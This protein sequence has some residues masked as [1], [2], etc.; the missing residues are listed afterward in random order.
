MGTLLFLFFSFAGVQCV[1]LGFEASTSDP[2]APPTPEVLLYIA[3]VFGASLA[4]NVWIFYRVSGG[5]FNPAVTLGIMLL[6]GMPITKGVILIISQ[7]V[8]GIAAAGLVAAI[9]PGGVMFATTLSGGIS[10]TQGL[11]FEAF[12]TFELTFTIYMVRVSSI[13]YDTQIL[14]WGH[15]YSLLLRKYVFAQLLELY[16]DISGGFRMI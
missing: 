6:G 2:N 4:A 1:K 13:R 9:L 16:H 3:I 10:V 14:T 11:F 12:L 5:L 15:P 7:L 8:G